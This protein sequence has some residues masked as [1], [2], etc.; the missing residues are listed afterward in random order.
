MR[1]Q[2]MPVHCTVDAGC[3]VAL[4]AG[5]PSFLQCAQELCKQEINQTKGLQAVRVLGSLNQAL[6][7]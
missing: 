1:Q 7:V 4:H 2:S 5:P 3:T 6:D